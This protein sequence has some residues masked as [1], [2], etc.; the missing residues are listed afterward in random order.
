MKSPHS[1]LTPVF[2][3]LSALSLLALAS[4]ASKQAPQPA[5]PVHV[6]TISYWEGDGVAGAPKIVIDL[7]DQVARYYKGGQI[8]GVSQISSGREGHGTTTGSFRVTEKDIDHRSSIYGSYV[9]AEGH[10]M[11]GDVDA[12]KDPKPPGTRFVGASMRYFMRINGGIGMHEGYLPGVPASHGCI[13]MPTRMAEIFYHA[14]PQGTP[15]QI[16]GHGSV[17]AAR[18]PVPITEQPAPQVAAS[19]PATSDTPN[20]TP[21]PP[22]A[23]KKKSWGLFKREPKPPPIPRGT[24]LYLHE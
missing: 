19:E 18:S 3:S 10:V 22:P 16:V 15:V 9:D 7:S 13:R 24:T 21:A 1:A 8:V 11:D 2:R 6:D 23:T 4:C 12:R 14:T 20:A 17:A 5:A